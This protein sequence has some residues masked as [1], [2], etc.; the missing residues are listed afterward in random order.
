L[1]AQYLI[2]SKAANDLEGIKDSLYLTK[3]APMLLNEIIANPTAITT[4]QSDIATQITQMETFLQ[5]LQTKYGD[6]SST[7]TQTTGQTDQ[8]PNSLTQE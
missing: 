1:G 6:V 8:I 7:P 4:M 5:S 3:K 2:A